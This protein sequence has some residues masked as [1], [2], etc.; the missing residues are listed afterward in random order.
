[1]DKVDGIV[2]WWGQMCRDICVEGEKGRGRGGVPTH[3]VLPWL[4]CTFFRL[5]DTG[6]VVGKRREDWMRRSR[7]GVKHVTAGHDVGV[8]LG[9][10]GLGVR[11]LAG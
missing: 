2:C 11:W 8:C 1:M 3:T 7:Q 4:S 9:R 5:I 10:N 6:N